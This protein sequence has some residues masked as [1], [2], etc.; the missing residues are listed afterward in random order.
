MISQ[1]KYKKTITSS[2]SSTSSSSKGKILVIVESPAKCSKIES[3]LGNDYHCIA[4]YGHFRQLDGLKSIDIEN[5][6]KPSFISIEEKNS[7]ISKMRNEIHSASNVIL[8]TDDDREGEAIAWHICDTFNLN[9]NS[10]P[11]I[12][13]HEITKPAIQHAIQNPGLINMN[14]VHAQLARQILDLLV[15][16]N[17]SP[18]LWSHISSNH[19]NALSAGRCQSPALRLVYDNDK[20]I[21]SSPGE[22]AYNIIGYFTKLN[23]QYALQYQY[24]KKEEVENFLIESSNYEHIFELMLPKKVTKTPPL[25]F[26]TSSLQQAASNEYHYSPKDT[27]MLCQKLYE[28]GYIT[29]MRTDCKIYS[30]EFIE[31]AKK[32]INETWGEKFVHQDINKLTESQAS[33]KQDKKK[34]KKQDDGVKA[35]EAHE[36]IRPTDITRIKLPDTLHPREIKMYEL[37]WKNTVESCM[38]NAI[39][40]SLTSKISS[41]INYDYRYTCELIEFPGWKIVNGYEKECPAYQYLS[42]IKNKS[43]LPY[44]KIQAK[45]TM[46]NLKSHFTEAGLVK[47]LEEKGIGR[48]STFSSLIDKIQERG[49]VKKEDVKG[50]SIECIDY[51]LIGDELQEIINNREFGNEKNKLVIQPI[52]IIVIEFLTTYFNTLFNYEFT[53]HMEDKLDI[54]AKGNYEWY[55]LCRECLDS[56]NLLTRQLKELGIKKDKIQLDN[57]HTFTIGRN[58]PVIK[59]DAG[60][61]ENGKK[62]TQLKAIKKNIDIEKLK[63]G[64]YNLDEIIDENDSKILNA[65]NGGIIL[66]KYN[67]SDL[68]LKNGKFGYY[69]IWGENKKSLPY[70]KT[71]N[72]DSITRDDVIKILENETN[73]DGTSSG[74]VRR[75]NDNI[76]IRKGKYGDYI[77]YKTL[78]MKKP[79]FYKLKDFSED[80]KTCQINIILEWIKQSYNIE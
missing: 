71:K 2:T 58:G 37:I 54:I 28:E 9:I 6:F 44:N 17:I 75:L 72:P 49:Y 32:Y 27:M 67:D 15:G 21:K 16:Y 20:D 51:E 40:S 11:R 41:P 43:I 61:D 19:K 18:Q 64:E 10:T 26:S 25:P 57:K 35:Q 56:I 39:C 79:D 45:V 76:S 65:N 77:F 4:S 30:A 38:S 3:Y 78:Q 14:L 46:N 12:I 48:P 73:N 5:N 74:C 13:F 8:A 55:D 68:I 36:A 42:N 59:F 29:Y 80:Y 7:Q 24:K 22:Q 1:K 66:G 34:N 63:K 50:S 69:V 70:S 53:K 60:I 47:I 31:K 33:G 23:L 62:I 52:G